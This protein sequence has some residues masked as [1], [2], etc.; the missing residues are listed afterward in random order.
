[1][2]KTD[3]AGFFQKNP[4]F[5]ILGQTGPKMRFLLIFS[6][7]ALTIFFIFCRMK[8]LMVWDISAKTACQKKF[9]FSRYGPKTVFGH[10]RHAQNLPKL[11][12]SGTACP[13]WLICCMVFRNHERSIVNIKK[14]EYPYDVMHN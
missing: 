8:V 11:N 12:I 6:K 14:I 10:A 5:E 1:M 4:I 13:F 9:W 7:T 3:E 2:L